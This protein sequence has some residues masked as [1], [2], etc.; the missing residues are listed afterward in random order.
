MV[1]MGTSSDSFAESVMLWLICLLV[2][3]SN[4]SLM[5]TTEFILTVIYIS[6]LETYSLKTPNT[7]IAWF[8][9][10][11]DIYRITMITLTMDISS[12]MMYI[13]KQIKFSINIKTVLSGSFFVQF[14]IKDVYLFDK[15]I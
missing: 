8:T 9:I 2:W 5:A 13:I 11:K 15:K 12:M 6:E 10:P 14:S 4:K 7:A 1:T 3:Y